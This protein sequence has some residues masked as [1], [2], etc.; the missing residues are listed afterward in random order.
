MCVCV[1]VQ[2]LQRKARELESVREEFGTQLQLLEAEKRQLE[3]SGRNTHDYMYMPAYLL[4]LYLSVCLSVSVCLC[5]S[6]CLCLSVYLHCF[7]L[8]S[9]GAASGRT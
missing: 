5:P 7:L 9:S 2:L 6:V 4:T 8:C 1:C 3:M